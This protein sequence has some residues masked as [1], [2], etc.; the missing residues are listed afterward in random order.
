MRTRA[1]YWSGYSIMSQ[2]QDDVMDEWKQSGGQER[3]T[4]EP[5][6]TDDESLELMDALVSAYEDVL[7]GDASTNSTVR[8]KNIA[9]TLRGLEGAGE[10][11]DVIADANDELGR[12][13]NSAKNSRNDA[14]K[15]LVRLGLAQVRPDVMDAALEARNE[16]EQV[17]DF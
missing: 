3:H 13:H 4:S 6:S 11:G 5:S 8:D 10:L 9:A 16:V 2:N 17:D 15:A 12:D 7:D 14:L 1:N